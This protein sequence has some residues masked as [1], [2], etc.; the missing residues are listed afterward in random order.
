MILVA[1]T[2]RCGTHSAAEALN[3]GHE[4]MFGIDQF[5]RPALRPGGEA[6]LM[7]VPWIIKQP[8]RMHEFDTR[9]H[10]VREPLACISSLKV[11]GT[12][13]KKRPWLD[14]H[15]SFVSHMWDINKIAI[16]YYIYWNIVAEQFCEMT[17]RVE[18]QP[19]WAKVSKTTRQK[20][21]VDVEIGSMEESG[22]TLLRQK[23]GYGIGGEIYPRDTTEISV[24]ET[25]VH[26]ILTRSKVS[27]M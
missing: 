14:Q 13:L 16:W 22:L 15:F 20:P 12:W 8:L 23:Y 17:I 1:G 18:D 10:L 21:M 25:S 19:E 9:I 3:I 6:S 4:R 2:G 11:N 27:P 24:G 7:A 5:A 26:A